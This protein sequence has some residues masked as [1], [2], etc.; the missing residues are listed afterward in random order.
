LWRCPLR[1]C[2]LV[3]RANS[4]SSCLLTF[5]L[6]V[7]VVEVLFKDGAQLVSATLGSSAVAAVAVAIV[8]P[9]QRVVTDDVVVI[10]WKMV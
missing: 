4:S 6:V 10:V 5:A 2:C 9:L 8:V 3:C 7:D 1:R